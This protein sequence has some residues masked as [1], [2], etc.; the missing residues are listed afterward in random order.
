MSSLGDIVQT[1]GISGASEVADAL[2]RLG[3][4]GVTAFTQL[5]T[6][7]T[8]ANQS[9]AAVSG[10]V[11]AASSA[12]ENFI[13][14][15][16]GA[17]AGI[18]A[19][20][21]A[22]Y[23]ITTLVANI[24]ESIVAAASMAE[25]FGM[26]RDQLYGMEAALNGAGISMTAINRAMER[27]AISVADGWAA[28]QKSTREGAAQ[29]EA[30][31]LR[32]A[33]AHHSVG[34]AV[35]KESEGSSD[36]AL[37]IEGDSISVADA[38]HSVKFASADMASQISNDKIAVSSAAIGIA[39]AMHEVKFAAA[40]MASE[41]SND[42]L[43]VQSAS[44]AVDQA[45]LRLSDLQSGRPDKGR[46]KELQLRQASLSVNQAEQ[47]RS[48]AEL[49]LSKDTSAPG[50]DVIAGQKLEAAMQKMSDAL[51]K[52]DKDAS[53]PS[54][55][56][57]ADHK[58]AEAL[59]KQSNDFDKMG[60]ALEKLGLDVRAAVN[61]L[62]EALLQQYD[63]EL[64]D[65][66]EI[67]KALT[68]QP[69]KVDLKDVAPR[70]IRTAIGKLAGDKFR[71]GGSP[72][73]LD[74]FQTVGELAKKKGADGQFN[75]NSQQLEAI[76]R[77]FGFRG[78]SAASQAG[79]FFRTR[80][81]LEEA[82]KGHGPSDE[83]VADAERG[84]RT[85]AD[86][87]FATRNLVENHT[88][89]GSIAGGIADALNTTTFLPKLVGIFTSASD[90][91]EGMMKRVLTSAGVK[92][93]PPPEGDALTGLV[94]FFGGKADGKADG[95]YISGPGSATSDS[96][97]A[98]LSNG[99]FVQKASAV[100]YWGRDFMESINNLSMP[101]FA[102]GGSVQLPGFA[103]GGPV[104][105]TVRSASGAGRGAGSTINLSID[106]N[107]FDGLIAPMHVADKLTEYARNRELSSAG[108]KPSWVR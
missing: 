51:L 22:A 92:L 85:Q 76:M 86:A 21:A 49:K 63:K 1:I 37:K 80:D 52:Y 61:H 7:A 103:M 105:S 106:G 60:P 82:N 24:N 3:S 6:S 64:H 28:I 5:G 74:E 36:W 66:Q 93:T 94:K 104:M 2:T 38:M 40:D 18:A 30:A 91:W 34:E 45:R 13:A 8:A 101:R 100:S 31:V 9:L 14:N 89:E 25:A 48:D 23:G 71:G 17:A 107:R 27:T 26:T 75:I 81:P 98:R 16:E 84:V 96:V 11:G 97:F 78:G 102:Q 57:E 15:A 42:L 59:T 32:V 12:F 70:D 39:E 77:E 79:R 35:R 68:G 67:G 87:R 46:A 62:T 54:K 73:E 95:G 44:L 56:G 72:N 29:E 65:L 88:G 50:K 10:N 69:S 90:Q 99:E 53:A 58:L 20:V 41:T 19:V 108:R 33:E 4:L 43:G 55:Q 83:R 47:Q